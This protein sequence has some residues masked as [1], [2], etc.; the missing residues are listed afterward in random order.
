MELINEMAENLRLKLKNPD[1]T[2][3]DLVA[4]RTAIQ[5]LRPEVDQLSDA[6]LPIAQKHFHE[7][8]GSFL[9]VGCYGGWMYPHVRHLVDYHGIDK[10]PAGI[11]CAKKLFGDDRFEMADMFEY[12]NKHDVVW[13]SQL[14]FGSALAG[15]EKCKSLSN[16]LCIYVSPEAGIELPGVSEFYQHQR[17]GVAIW[18]KADG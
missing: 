1:G 9:D 13:C 15:W 11:E 6:A 3:A 5:V 16:K 10:W 4:L 7:F 14:L 12:E 17:M 18:R 8:S 2:P